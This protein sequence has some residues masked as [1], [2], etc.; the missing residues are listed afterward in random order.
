M[1]KTKQEGLNEETKKNIFLR[2]TKDEYV[3]ILN[4]MGSGDVSQLPLLEI[5]DLCRKYSRS[6]NM[7]GKGICGPLTRVTKSTSG[8]VTRA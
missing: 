5:H 4:L 3:D 2:A 6:R 1:K 8:G 7:V